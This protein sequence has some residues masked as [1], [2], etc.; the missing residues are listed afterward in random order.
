MVKSAAGI[1]DDD[2]AGEAVEKL[3][4]ACGDDAVADL[5]G[6][7]SGLLDRF[8]DDSGA[9]EIIW[10]AHEWAIELAAAQPLVLCFEDIHWAEEPCWI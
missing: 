9:P 3:R 8:S 10:A 2:P 4:E 6:L 5:L 7:A 1:S